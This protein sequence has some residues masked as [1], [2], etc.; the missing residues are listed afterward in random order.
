LLSGAAT[1]LLAAFTTKIALVLPS[2]TKDDNVEDESTNSVVPVSSLEDAMQLIELSCNKRFLH[3]V[4]ASDYKL[5]YQEGTQMGI[6]Q[7]LQPSS[8]S[9]LQE[10]NIVFRDLQENQFFIKDHGP[11]LLESCHLALS[12]KTLQRRSWRD[13]KTLTHLYISPGDGTFFLVDLYP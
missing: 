10:E 5:L 1:L 3:A 2:S 6:R 8:S 7:Q 9:L 11:L 12:H 4:V 13:E